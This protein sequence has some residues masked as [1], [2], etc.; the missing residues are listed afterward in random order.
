MRIVVIDDTPLVASVVAEALQ[1]EGH[2][3]FPSTDYLRVGYERPE[4]SDEGLA[5][6]RG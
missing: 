2:Y 3:G 5:A 6:H 4:G 1:S